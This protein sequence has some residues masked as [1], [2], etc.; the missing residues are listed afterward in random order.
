[1]NTAE[2]YKFPKDL[3]RA[4]GYVCQSTGEMVKFTPSTK[5]VY[6]Y[7]ISRNEFFTEKRKG[8]HFESQKV[9]ADSCGM[10]EKACGKILRK[11]MEHGLIEGEKKQPDKGGHPRYY[12]KTVKTDIHLW[13]GCARKPELLRKDSTIRAELV[14][15]R[16]SLPPLEIY[17]NIQFEEDE[18]PEFHI[19]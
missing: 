12:Y 17:D 3:A 9:I 5:I 10:E 14:D 15:E 1:M 2:F 16:D 19:Y 13:I 7:M 18:S 4:I 11:M 6:A 8:H